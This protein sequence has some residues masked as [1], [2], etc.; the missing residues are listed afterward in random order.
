MNEAEAK[1]QQQQKEKL[2]KALPENNF[3]FQK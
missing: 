1:Q 2:K 3:F